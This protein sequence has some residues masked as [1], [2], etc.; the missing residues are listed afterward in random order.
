MANLNSSEY[1]KDIVVIGLGFVGLTL[2]LKLSEKTPVIG[3]EKDLF[4]VDSINNG[5]PH[6]H[7]DGI[8]QVLIKSIKSNK[9]RA[10]NDLS[11][12]TRRSRNTVFII[13]IGTPVNKNEKSVS[14][15]ILNLLHEMYPIIEDQDIIILRS[16][17]SVGTS[18]FVYEWF[19]NKNKHVHVAFCPERTIEGKALLELSNLPQ[20]ISGTTEVAINESRALFS[21]F[22]NQIITASSTRIAELAKLSSNIERDVYFSFANE[23]GFVAKE[24]SLDFSELKSLVSTDYPR[25]FLKEVGPV[26]GPC[27]EKDTYILKQS[28]N[29]NYIM[30]LIET[31]RNL[32]EGWIYK[33]CDEILKSFSLSKQLCLTG[34]A[35]KGNPHT[36]DLRGSLA[37]PMYKYLIQKGANVKL[38]DPTILKTDVVNYFETDDFNV[39][40]SWDEVLNSCDLIVLQNGSTHICN[41][42]KNLNIKF[43]DITSFNKSILNREQ[44]LF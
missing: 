7:E 41:Q 11:I 33:V 19:I 38:F 44:R 1:D 27:L 10:I 25:S 2:S 15:L 31:A 5:I 26:A 17:V 34:L 21:L 20:I 29:D 28:F 37:K 43:L 12:Y 13:T 14:D 6:F 16:T 32:N 36:D 30:N 23:L 3:L 40:N 9:F 35:F 42:C 39:F 4:K 24:L 8:N 22:C 18:D